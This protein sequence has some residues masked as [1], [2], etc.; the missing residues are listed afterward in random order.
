M[1]P[2]SSGVGTV[3]SGRE[4][5]GG[6]KMS[7]L[8]EAA[9]AVIGEFGYLNLTRIEKLRAAVERAENPPA[10]YN[11]WTARHSGQTVSPYELWTAAQQAERER[12]REI[13]KTM[14]GPDVP[15]LLRQIDSREE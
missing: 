13:V 11:E 12:C 2:G 8:L 15:D 7:D 5:V 10:N 6:S 9:K 14:G 4:L 3:G 1:V